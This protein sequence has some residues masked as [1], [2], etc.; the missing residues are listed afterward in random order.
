MSVPTYTPPQQQ[1]PRQS[2]SSLWI[3]LAFFGSLIVMASIAFAL[4][5]ASGVFTALNILQ[6]TGPTPVR[7]YLSITHQDYVQAYTLLDSHATINGQQVDEQTFAKMATDAD[8][9]HGK[10]TG[11]ILN[12]NGNNSSQITV[13][14]Y[15]GHQ[16]YQVHLHL[17]LEG[18]DWKIVSADGI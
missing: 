12:D 14:V 5:V 17:K 8:T 18:T 7:Y 4:L 9:Q 15:R 16:N 13:T 1:Q 3:G 10:V 6:Q 11:F 2:R